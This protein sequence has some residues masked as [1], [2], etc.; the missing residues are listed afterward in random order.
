M[1]MKRILKL[2]SLIIVAIPVVMGVGFVSAMTY[3]EIK[4]IKSLANSGYDSDTIQQ[5]CR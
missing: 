5:I 3:N 4:C 2:I 1:Q